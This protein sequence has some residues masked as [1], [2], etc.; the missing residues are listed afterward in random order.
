MNK[1]ST[2]ALSVALALGVAACSPQQGE[3]T[4]TAQQ[5]EQKELTSGLKLADFNTEVR[6]QDDL[7]TYV[8]GGWYERTELPADKS[9]IGSFHE[10]R[11]ENQE[12][13][14]KIIET[15]AASNPEP[16]SN[17]AKLGNFYNSFMDVERLNSLGITPIA[18]D[19]EA[20]AL[21]DNHTDAATHMATHARMGVSNPF[22]FYVY[23]DAKDPE[24]NAMYMSQSGLGLP[25]RDY[26]LKDEEKFNEIRAQYQDYI[27]DM[28]ELVGYSE[29]EAAAEAILELET[30]LAE[31][32]W[33]RVESR[34]ADKTYNKHTTAELQ[35]LFGSFDFAAFAE[36]AGITV[37]DAAIVRQPS[38]F[39]AFG[40]LFDNVPLETWKH[41]MTLK[42][43]DR[44]SSA[45]TEE[46]NDR[47]FAFYGAV[48]QG[49]PEQEERWKRGVSATDN[50]LGEVLG[51]VYVA[52]YFPPEA[53]ARMEELVDNLIVAYGDSIQDLEWMTDE[54][55]QKALEKLNKFTPY[56]GYPSEW[57]DYSGLVVA[58]D[59]LVGNYKRSRAFDYEENI[60]KI[61]KPV[62]EED[63]G[64]TP[65]TVNAYYSPVRNEIVFPAGILQ[66]PFFNMNAEDA[67][68]YG[69]IGAVIGHELGHGFDDQG[70]KYDGEGNL[71]SWWTDDDRNAF[72]ERGG[73]LAAQYD[74][75]EVID[76]VFINGKLTLG[77]NIGD[78][79][80][81]TIAYRAYQK[82]LGD[83]SAPVMDGFTGEQRVFLGW[84]QVWK[85]KARDEYVRNQVLSD[86]HAPADY[87]VNGTVVN[88]P[89]FYEAFDVK[90]GDELYLPPE[91]RVTIW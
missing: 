27:A 2:L 57:R 9:R 66:P 67:V 37:A 8:N 88:I 11:D 40:E 80:G 44:F 90:P 26:Y 86:P 60:S 75:Y 25:D 76:D 63:W 18:G 42:L 83:E 43:V 61:G 46:I 4:K 58:T 19:L 17:E 52:E 77:E 65:Q 48:L 69:G 81:L 24:T 36:P 29:T 3:Q 10:L 34:N 64:M 15:A 23:P 74:G 70:S 54:T 45:L 79:A 50:A 47:R 20:I 32:Q 51:Q 12:R 72:D 49:T 22:G 68:N 28:L 53:K 33:S 89:A 87:R 84:A 16:R 6:P 91:E 14:R 1:V 55:K 5:Q 73:K 30:K 62:D 56:I 31:I 59:D 13:L 35:E 85:N 39:N 71:R 78:L 38:Y 21:L 41:Y 7:F 82:S